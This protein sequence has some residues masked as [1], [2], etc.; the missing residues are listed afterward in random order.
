[1]SDIE[2]V[3]IYK[4]NKTVKSYED[5]LKK[6][7]KNEPFIPT[8]KFKTI[9]TKDINGNFYFDI[10]QSKSKTA[11]DIP[12]LNFMNEKL[13]QKEQ[14]NSANVLPRGLFIY[15]IKVDE[16]DLFF[17]MTF[18]VGADSFI[19]KDKVIS[20]F[21]IKIAM[22]IC[23]PEAIKSIQTSQHEAISIQ[24]EKQIHTGAG[25]SIF[26]IEY[27]EEFFKKIAG[28]AK[29]GY[30]FVS[31]VTGTE[32]IQLKFDKK[33]KLTWELLNDRT[34]TLE[35]LYLSDEYKNTEFRSFDN[36]KY[37]TKS[38]IID[39]L[40]SILIEKLNN[41]EFEKISLTIPEFLDM[42]R[43][44][45]SYKKDDDNEVDDLILMDL[46]ETHNELNSERTL[47]RWPIIKNDKATKTSY[48]GW[49]AYQCIVAEVDLEDKTYILFNGKWREISQVF[50]QNV[51]NYISQSEIGFDK[52]I[53][54]NIPQDL[55]IYDAVSGY[56]KEAVFNTECAKLNEDL[57]LFDKAK[58]RIANE[59]KYEICDIFSLNKELIQVKKYESG[60]SSI[61]H[62]FVQAK[63]YADAFILEDELRT[64][65]KQFIT[66]ECIKI[67]SVNY[68][69][70][71]EEF[72]KLIPN[73][74]PNENE[75]TI[76]LCILSEKAIDLMN[77]P[78]MSL[79]SIYQT[80]KYLTK[81]RNYNVKFINRE[82]VKG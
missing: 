46:L 79:Y 54:S 6:N 52:T 18:G 2:Q 53:L 38:S 56:N 62:L 57:F 34:K 65:M 60:A 32:R 15:S 77:L 75:Y 23:D 10:S 44:T 27:D 45:F 48:R 21:G 39:K 67:G 82:I 80:H 61:S 37:E 73:K 36:W 14:F 22:N 30:T 13:E 4:M 58:L 76:I 55:N 16:K 7:D 28:K 9:T 71:K 5:C 31:S 43:Y 20:D 50:K 42:D 41:Q 40:N 3:V 70:N 74:R 49:S 29:K 19:D 51:V 1:M 64:H 47:K 26:N 24:S 66:E 59:A 12:W 81:H 63:F 78:F 8:I 69:K 68:N 33:N 35:D 11:K 17:A 72:L 25:L